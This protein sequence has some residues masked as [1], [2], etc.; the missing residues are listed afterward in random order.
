MSSEHAYGKPLS[1]L[2]GA[3]KMQVAFGL[4]SIGGKDSMSGTF[5]HISVPPT[6]IAFGIT[7]VPEDKVEGRAQ[8]AIADSTKEPLAAKASPIPEEQQEEVH[9]H[10]GR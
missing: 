5:E 3:L 10:R 9:F 6:L 7:T 4:P 2:L 1:A 8:E